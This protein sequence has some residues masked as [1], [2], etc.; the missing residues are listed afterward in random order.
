MNSDSVTFFRALAR[1]REKVNTIII[2]KIHKQTN[3]NTFGLQTED[4][5]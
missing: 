1:N 2:N 4:E 3:L 5:V